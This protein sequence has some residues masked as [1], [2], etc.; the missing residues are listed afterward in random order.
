MKTP[1]KINNFV[2]KLLHDILPTFFNLN[3]RGISVATNC[4]LCNENEETMTHLFL[5]CSFARACWHGSTLA[6]H[7]SNYSN[8]SIQQWLT[9]IINKHNIKDLVSIDYLQSFFTTLWTIW[10]HR[11]RVVHEGITPNPL[12][13]ILIAQSLSCRYKDAFSE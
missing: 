1:Q 10:N 2:W 8:T 12:Q 4:P 5:I 13:V 11:N 6:I 7:S 9:L 3:H